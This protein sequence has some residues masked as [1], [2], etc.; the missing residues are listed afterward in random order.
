MAGETT[1]MTVADLFKLYL[2]AEGKRISRLIVPPGKEP[3]ENFSDLLAVALTSAEALLQCNVS[4]Q[5]EPRWQRV[6]NAR[7]K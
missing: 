3:T 5:L 1:E 2:Q 6:I 7:K 4:V